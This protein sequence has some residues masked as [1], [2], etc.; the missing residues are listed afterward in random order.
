MTRKQ[1]RDQVVQWIGLQDIQAYDETAL[2][3]D[4]LYQGTIDLLA[5]TRCVVRCVQLRT[6]VGEDTY[7]L[8]HGILALVDVENGSRPKVDRNDSYSP[9]FTMIR[10]DLLRLEPPPAANGQTVQVWG[11]MRPLQMLLDTDSPGDESYGA[12]PDEFHDAIVTYGQWKASDYADD[13]SGQMG[14]K[15]RILYEGPQGNAG[16][17]G[18]IR[19]QVNKR[20]TA[21]ATRSRVRVRA[22]S[23]P[24]TWTG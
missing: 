17:L 8:D 7:K 5:R 18:Q 23:A 13:A 15:Y 16:R 24:G 2:V 9:S 14:E 20:G 11:V 10:A 19:A 3:N 21:R 22:L 12:I 4:L 1:M 6:T